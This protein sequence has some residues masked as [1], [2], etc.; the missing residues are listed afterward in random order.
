MTEVNCCD[1]PHLIRHGSF[2]EGDEIYCKACGFVWLQQQGQTLEAAVA[3]WR[4]QPLLS[5][6]R[7]P[8]LATAAAGLNASR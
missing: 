8:H 1:R 4:G 5:Q 3:E 6:A 7:E 2:E